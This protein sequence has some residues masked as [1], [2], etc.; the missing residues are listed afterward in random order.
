MRDTIEKLKLTKFVTMTGMVNP[1]EVPNF[2]KAADIFVSASQSET[3]GLTYIEAI[4]NGLALV[5]KYDECLE[6]VLID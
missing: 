5:C 6:N 2:Y 1:E 3:Q 4:S